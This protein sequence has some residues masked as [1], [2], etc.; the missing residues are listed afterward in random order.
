MWGGDLD[1]LFNTNQNGWVAY[2]LSDRF[3]TKRERSIN[4]HT[5]DV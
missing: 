5:I 1:G 2:Y 4:N 3:R